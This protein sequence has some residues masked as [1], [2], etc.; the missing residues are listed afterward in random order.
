[1]AASKVGVVEAMYVW[2]SVVGTDQ[3]DSGGL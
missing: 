3:V 1:M 2:V